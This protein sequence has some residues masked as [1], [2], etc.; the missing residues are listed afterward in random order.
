VDFGSAAFLTHAGQKI[1]VR[2]GG[3]QMRHDFFK[4]VLA[5]LEEYEV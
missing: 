3:I 5:E 4:G 1:A 2:R